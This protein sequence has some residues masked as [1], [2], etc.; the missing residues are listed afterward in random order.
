MKTT[1]EIFSVFLIGIFLCAYSCAGDATN[2]KFPM[3]I[4]INNKS[5][6]TEVC[7]PVIVEILLTNRAPDPIVIYSQQDGLM[8]N[9]RVKV[10]TEDG[11]SCQL[12]RFAEQNKFDDSKVLG[13]RSRTIKP[14]E[15]ISEVYRLNRYFDMTA[16]GIYTIQ[17]SRDCSTGRVQSTATSNKLEIK[18]NDVDDRKARLKAAALEE[19][20]KTFKTAHL[21]KYLY[22]SKDRGDLNFTQKERSFVERFIQLLELYEN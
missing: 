10:Y 4:T 2:T 11:S 3:E 8:E 18:I 13:T 1:D 6:S 12:T 9:Y 20:L 22:D 19:E 15:S 21:R 17:L 7:T 5:T 16:H 14:G